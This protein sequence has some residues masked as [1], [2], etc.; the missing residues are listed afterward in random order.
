[1]HIKYKS[2][3]WMRDCSTLWIMVEDA[4][5]ENKVLRTNFIHLVYTSPGITPSKKVSEL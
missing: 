5:V 1:M 2:S 3:F 4:S